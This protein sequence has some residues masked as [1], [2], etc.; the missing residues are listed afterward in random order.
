MNPIVRRLDQ[1][2]EQWT[3]FVSD[4]DAPILRWV[5]D[6]ENWKMVDAFVELENSDAGLIPDLFVELD[7]PFEGSHDHGYGL[8]AQFVEKY[9]LSRQDLEDEDLDAGWEPPPAEAAEWDIGALLHCCASFRAYYTDLLEH[10]VLVL[11]PGDASDTRLWQTWV[12]RL[13]RTEVPPRI[14]FLVID[15]ADAPALDGIAE[16]RPDRIV[17]QVIDLEMPRAYEELTRGGDPGV[18]G[19][20]FRRQF[21]AMGNA[22]RSGDLDAAQESARIALAIATEHGWHAQ[23]VTVNMGLGGGFLST[24]QTADA[25]AAYRKAQEFAGRALEGKEEEQEVGSKLL[26]QSRMAEAAVHLGEGDC[27]EAARLY[28]ETALTDQAGDD[29]FLG[30]ECWRMAALSYQKGGDSERAW[31]CGWQALVVGEQL[32]QEERPNS[33][34]AYAGA[35]LRR[36]CESPPYDE[37]A[38]TVEGRMVELLGP[39]WM[40][41]GLEPETGETDL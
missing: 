40:P 35:A 22:L 12:D 41:E 3:G 10:L 26:V 18:P 17:S 31:S 36:L 16:A 2:R 6:P 9:Q 28:H 37:R 25:I 11:A 20:L 32:D 1:L 29:L 15:P 24:G 21:V 4:S 7:P 27:L 13:A 23:A 8:R 38:T 39:D 5:C 34:L 14:R 30:L 19:V 33:S